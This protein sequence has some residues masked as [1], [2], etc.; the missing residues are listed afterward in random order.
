MAFRDCS[1]PCS[2]GWLTDVIISIIK[3]IEYRSLSRCGAISITIVD[4]SRV[5]RGIVLRWV[6]HNNFAGSID[7]KYTQV[8]RQWFRVVY[9]DLK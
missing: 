3:R 6:Q 9:A 2:G 4:Q 7:D 1:R 8:H 5:N